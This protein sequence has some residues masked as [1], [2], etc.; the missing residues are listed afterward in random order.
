MDIESLERQNDQN[1]AALG[2]RV[3]LLRNVCTFHL[4]I[5]IKH[6]CV[7]PLTDAS[8]Y[9]VQ[10]TSGIH[11]E[12]ETHHSLLDKMTINIGG[13]QIGIGATV[14]KVSKVMENPQGRRT[15]YIAVSIVLI[16]FFFFIWAR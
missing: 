8:Y 2:E 16:M 5:I 10:I 12:V 7:Y 1:I 6:P 4:I 13:A 9:M 14:K 15:V 11:S 3:G